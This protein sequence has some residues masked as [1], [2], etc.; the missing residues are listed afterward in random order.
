LLLSSVELEAD[1]GGSSLEEDLFDEAYN[2]IFSLL[3]DD[4]FRRFRLTRS[5]SQ[6]GSIQTQVQSNSTSKR[7]CIEMLPEFTISLK[8]EDKLYFKLAWID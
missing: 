7:T 2:A 4:S 5:Q 3:L 1:V 8:S 6:I